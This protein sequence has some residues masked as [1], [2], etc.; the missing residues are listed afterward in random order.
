MKRLAFAVFAL[1]A[2]FI[3]LP[4]ASSAQAPCAIDAPSR[5]GIDQAFTLCGPTGGGYRYE[6]Y[7]PGLDADAGARCVTA[8]VRDSGTY[9]YLLVVKRNGQELDRCKKVVNVGNS[10]GGAGSCSITGPTSIQAG[11]SARLCAPDD[12][13]HIY[14]WTG[15]NGFTSTSAC[16]NVTE[17]GTYYLTSRNRLTGSSRQCTHRLDVIGAS[18]G[19]ESDCISGPTSIPRNGTA[20]LCAPSRGAATYRWT[21][22]RGFTGSERC[23]TIDEPGT[24]TV[25][26][27]GGFTGR[28]ERCSLTVRSRGWGGGGGGGGGGGWGGGG[29]NDNGDENPDD[30]VW[31]NCPRPFQFWRDLYDDANGSGDLSSADLRAI[32][33]WVDDH[34]TYFNW[35]DDLQGMRQAL[36]PESPMTRSKQL[37]RQY[38]A[39]LANVAAGELGA[40][41]Q[42]RNQIS[43]DL[44]TQVDFAGAA[45]LRDLISMTDRVLGGRRGSFS[46]L[47]AKLTQINRGQGIGPVCD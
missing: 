4:R 38:A 27:R 14:R 1:A 11:Q 25:S 18:G 6:W 12:G 8:R 13:L 45:T 37:A 46:R 24:Y 35:R 33:R 20:E 42:G 43:L 47:N 29:G 17:E 9:E 36:L 30:V 22:P 31:D 34:S 40:T 39:L 2:S 15:P 10:A 16:V 23:V 3:F 28:E 44:D 26:I 32:A 19:G 5:V 41:P 7:G 21:G